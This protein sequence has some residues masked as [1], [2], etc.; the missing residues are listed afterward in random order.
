MHARA[1]T[2]PMTE[3]TY[4]AAGVD[5]D[6]G[7]EIKERIKDIAAPTFGPEVL[8][9]VG[10]FGAMYQLSGY[11]EPVLV[12]STDGVGTK[13]KI[14]I[15]MDRLDTIGEDL[16]NACVNDVV[17][18]GARPL[19]FLDYI[20][21]GKLKPDRVEVLLTGM[22][23]A[24]KE[25]ECALIGGETAQMPGLYAGSDFDL[26]GFVVG[27]VEKSAMVDPTTI[28]E[29]DVLLGIPSNGLH[30][31]GYSLVRHVLALDDDPSPLSE[32]HSELGMT[33]GESLL[34]PHPSYYQMLKPLFSLVKGIAHITGGGLVENVPRV[35]P[36]GLG[37]R[38]DTTTWRLPPIFSLLQEMGNVSRE[39]MYRVFNMGLGMV[40]VCDEARAAEIASLAPEATVIGEVV[41]PSGERRVVL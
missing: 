18:S 3:H 40:L 6:A 38:L 30:T 21:T 13:L 33:L 34:T 22:A 16:V 9:G 35:L 27:V 5:L 29:G 37:A 2:I 26:A 23:R 20:A 7:Q 25:V 19:F 41:R 39:E 8:A 17:V 28:R 12:S 32:F 24:C 4:I 11:R 10:A 1:N 31:N 15:M 36:D 14:A